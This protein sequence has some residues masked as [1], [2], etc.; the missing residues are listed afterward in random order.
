MVYIFSDSLTLSSP[1]SRSHSEEKEIVLLSFSLQLC[2][3]CNEWRKYRHID[4]FLFV[5]TISMDFI[6]VRIGLLITFIDI[7]AQHN[8]YQPFIIN[9]VRY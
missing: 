9:N 8:N 7:Y 1:R 4:D 3:L 5:K 2:H 6:Y